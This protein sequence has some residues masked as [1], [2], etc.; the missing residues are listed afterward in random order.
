MKTKPSYEEKYREAVKAAADAWTLCKSNHRDDDATRAYK[1]ASQRVDQL[2][3]FLSDE[4]I[5]RLD[6]ELGIEAGRDY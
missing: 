5:D 6:A 3:A 4:Q 1:D 2:C